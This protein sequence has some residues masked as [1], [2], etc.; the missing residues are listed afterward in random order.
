MKSIFKKIS[1]ELSGIQGVIAVIVYGSFARGEATP[2]SD[3]DLL[4]LISEGKKQKEIEDSIIG[5]E[6]KIKRNI[7]PTIRTMSGLQ[8]TDTGLLQN[9]FQEG[10]VL[11]LREPSEIPSAALLKQKPY[12]I[13]SFKINRLSQKEKARFD[14]LLYE[15]T[16]KGYKYRGLL[17]A[18]GGERLSPGCILVP[19]SQKEKIERYLKKL[20]VDFF[21]LKV[22]K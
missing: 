1:K 8:R 5:V 2:R 9:I 3:I 20:K 17:S 22:W 21:Q 4:I 10:K 19:F 13:Y 18:L 14:R 7:Q 12:L 6:A 11:Y 16:K 15:Q